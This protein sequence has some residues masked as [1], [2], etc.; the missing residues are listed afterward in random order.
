MFFKKLF[1][2]LAVFFHCLFTHH[3]TIVYNGQ[4]EMIWVK[5]EAYILHL[6]VSVY[7]DRCRPDR[8][9]CFR[10]GYAG[11]YSSYDINEKNRL[12]TVD[13]SHKPTWFKKLLIAW[14]ASFFYKTKSAAV[15]YILEFHDAYI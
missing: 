1:R 6:G 7:T 8:F 2:K 9:Y 15:P 11:I 5:Y 4:Y 10:P 3:R 13:Y 14:G 12:A